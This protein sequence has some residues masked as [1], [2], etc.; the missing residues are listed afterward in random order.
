MIDDLPLPPG[1][2]RKYFR[3]ALIGA[4]AW[5]I[6]WYKPGE[7][8]AEEIARQIV[9]LFR[10]G[11]GDGMRLEG[12]VAVVTGAARGIG[13]A[14]A[15]RFAAEGAAVVLA[16]ILEELG[17]TTAQAI[18]DG[19]GS[20]SEFIACDTGDSRPGPRADRADGLP[21]RAHRRA[22]EQR[23]HLHHR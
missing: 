10:S 17:E 19:G 11:G 16:D 12:K 2:S 15:R 5:S 20:A 14:C 1:T 9:N 3:L 4:M 13:A 18:R 6:A 22:G 8:S 23:R 21:P 7:D